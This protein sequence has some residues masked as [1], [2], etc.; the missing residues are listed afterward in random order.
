MG[1]CK[2][3]NEDADLGVRAVVGFDII[4]RRDTVGQADPLTHDNKKLERLGCFAVVAV[5]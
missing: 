2:Y 1:S 5:V 3:W 4:R